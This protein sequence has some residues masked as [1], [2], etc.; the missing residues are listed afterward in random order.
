MKLFCSLLLAVCAVVFGQDK[1]TDIAKKDLPKMA[2]CVVCIS[3]GEGHAQEKPAAGVLYKGQAYYFCNVNEVVDFK[4]NPDLYLPP[5]L[6]RA[7]PKFDLVDLTGKRWDAEAVKDKVV[8]IDYWA[9][10][11]VPCREMKPIIEKARAKFVA[12]GFEVLSVSIDEKRADLDKFLV[13]NK[14]ANP[15]LHDTAKTWAEWKVRVVPT[16]FLIKNGQVI[17]QWSGK[18][19]EAEVMKIIEAAFPTP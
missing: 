15:V 4:K 16:F 11:C 3:N 6:P 19:K 13:K 8:L 12:K 5:V 7:I 17:E 14:F 9:T 1:P 18:K 2:E 10:W